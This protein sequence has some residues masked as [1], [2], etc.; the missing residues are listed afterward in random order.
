[1]IVAVVQ[2]VDVVAGAGCDETVQSEIALKLATIN[3]ECQVLLHSH[4]HSLG[5]GTFHDQTVGSKIEKK[6]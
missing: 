4:T 1:V 5:F 2:V 3:D 6:I